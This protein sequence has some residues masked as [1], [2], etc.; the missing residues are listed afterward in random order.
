M[1]SNKTLTHK[2]SC[3]KYLNLTQSSDTGSLNYGFSLRPYSYIK[4]LY[5]AVTY[6]QTEK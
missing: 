4:I 3:A 5:Q 2:K 6:I 1:R